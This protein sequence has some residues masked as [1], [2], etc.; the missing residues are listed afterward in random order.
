M[1]YAGR[2]CTIAFAGHSTSAISSLKM[3]EIGILP[4]KERMYRWP[5][6]MK[7]SDILP[8]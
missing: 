6:I 5:G 7:T 4:P 2:D 1:E 8:E 3:Y